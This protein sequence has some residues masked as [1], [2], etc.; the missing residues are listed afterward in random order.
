M[1]A[2]RRQRLAPLDRTVPGTN[3][4]RKA[5]VG[6]PVRRP[7]AVTLLMSGLVL[8]WGSAFA[9]LRALGSELDP[10]QLTWFRYVPF[11]AFFGVW[12]VVARRERFGQVNG[13]DWVRFAAAG[14]LGVL[15]YHFPLNIGLHGEEGITAATAAILVATTPLWTLFY[16]LV[17]RQE[18]LDLGRAIGSLVA[19]AGVVVVVLLAPVGGASV[20]NLQRAGIA[21]LAP[22]LWGAYSL[23][24]KPLIGR[25]GGLFTTG[26][27]FCI[28]TA[29]LLPLGI[30]YGTAPLRGLDAGLWA[31]LLFIAVGAT[32]GGYAIWNHALKQRSATEVTTWIYVIPVVATAAG[33]L[34]EGE[35]VTAWFVLGA[36]LAIGGVFLVNRARVRAA[37]RPLLPAIETRS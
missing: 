8:M 4:I 11:L 2:L 31:W 5:I 15:G 7:D 13:A 16:A 1:R 10:F 25:Y 23:V 30:A 19:F 28:G 6:R 20:G 36:A 29:M 22:M 37:A 27:A 26:V 32:V 12:L 35:R 18:R 3:T 33:W 9:G 21:M 34:F 14:A 24:A 17:L